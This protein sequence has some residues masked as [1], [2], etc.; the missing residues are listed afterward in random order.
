M[1]QKTDVPLSQL[2]TF[3]NE[4]ALPTVCIFDDMKE[5]SDYV[6]GNDNFFVLGKGS[7]TVINPDPEFPPIVQISPNYKPPS[8]D[9]AVLEAG[10]GVT[11][12]QLM[13]ACKEFGVTGLE[14]MAGVPASVGGMVAMNF[15]CWGTEVADI[16]VSAEVM[17]EDGS[18]DVMLGTELQFS[19][20]NSI[21]QHE[22]FIVLSAKF[23]VGKDQPE[24]IK[25]R[26]NS[27]I[28]TRLDS[29]PL[30]DK[31]FGSTFRNPSGLYAGKLLDDYGF[32]G[33]RLGPV[34]F[35]E[36]HAN[37]MVNLGGATYDDVIRLMQRVESEIR[38]KR[39]LSLSAEVMLVS[40]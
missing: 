1:I 11:V 9:G 7:N 8:F 26:I 27:N 13:N 12:A 31:T 22:P 2:T 23:N 4:G 36:K 3:Q 16:L 30:R 39:G 21:F 10:A 24:V 14:F 5:L 35:S 32:K 6:D 29:Q 38:S 25:Q 20:R 15:G 18:I 19:Y 40:L 17:K 34:M 33:Y 37:F 28:Q